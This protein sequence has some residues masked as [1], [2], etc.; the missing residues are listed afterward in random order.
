MSLV[1][2]YIPT[3][4][5]RECISLLGD[6]GDIQFRDMNKNSNS[7]QRPYVNEIRNFDQTIRHLKFLTNQMKNQQIRIIPADFDHLIKKPSLDYEFF[8]RDDETHLT[9]GQIEELLV[10]IEAHQIRTRDLSTTNDLLKKERDQLIQNRM[11]LQN[12]RQFFDSRLSIELDDNDSLFNQVRLSTESTNDSFMISDDEN[13]LI[14]TPINNNNSQNN[15]LEA[16]TF[17]NNNS[18]NKIFSTGRNELNI[19]G[20]TMNFISGII[21][22][23]K[24][25]ILEKFVGDH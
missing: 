2:F 7:F 24:F 8:L 13:D 5:A 11:V 25:L 18:N 23:D 3:E 14:N 4:I 15:I 21:D 22:T 20:S 16:G 19:L 10:T 12:T 6:M 17:N 1:Q 9:S